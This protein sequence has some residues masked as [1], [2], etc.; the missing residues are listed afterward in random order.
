MHPKR[1]LVSLASALSCGPLSLFVACQAAG[2]HRAQASAT[3]VTTEI[4][5]GTSV[6]ETLAFL[7]AQLDSALSTGVDA[8][9]AR[10][11]DRAE[12]ISN[13]LLESR[14][15]FA[16]ISAEQYSLEARLRQIQARADRAEALLRDGAPREAI[17]AEVRGLLDAVAQ[18]KSELDAGGGT[19]PPP[20][21]HLLTVLDSARH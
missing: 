14:L 16:W 12:A 2:T 21:G 15:P 10:H 3:Q 9:V 6:R 4:G 13:R 17:A 11:L 7:Q 18:V 5:P 1:I 8:V 19:A 20:V